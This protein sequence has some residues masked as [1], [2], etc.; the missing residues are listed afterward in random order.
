[1]DP[2]DLIDIYRTFHPKTIHVFLIYLLLTRIT[3]PTTYHDTSFPVECAVEGV[4]GEKGN[5]LPKHKPLTFP[6]GQPSEAV[7][8]QWSW[9]LLLP[10]RPMPLFLGIK[11]AVMPFANGN[12]VEYLIYYTAMAPNGSNRKKRWFYWLFCLSVMILC[13]YNL[14]LAGVMGLY[15]SNS[16]NSTPGEKQH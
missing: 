16:D 2:L 3:F 8:Q 7:N 13:L 9:Q 11:W 4:S 15:S 10:V 1:M 5:W 12:T 14:Y 6:P